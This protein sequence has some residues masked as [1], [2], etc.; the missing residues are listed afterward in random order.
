MADFVEILV[1]AKKFIDGH[2]TLDIIATVDRINEIDDS[3]DGTLPA[4]PDYITDTSSEATRVPENDDDSD[5]S[6]SKNSKTV[7]NHSNFVG[8]SI[9]SEYSN[10]VDNIQQKIIINILIIQCGQYNKH[11][12]K[13]QRTFGKPTPINRSVNEIIYSDSALAKFEKEQ[14]TETWVGEMRQM[15]IHALDLQQL[16][17]GTKILPTG[18]KCEKC[19]LTRNLWLNLTDG[20]ILCGRKFFDGT[21]GNKHAAQHFSVSNYALAVKLG[22]I[23]ADGRADVFSYAE[24]DMVI[25]PY[26]QKHFLHFGINIGLTLRRLKSPWLRWSWR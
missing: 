13:I 10:G 18:W 6:S 1:R 11:F 14:L 17:N 23:S 2:W 12:L 21:G 9:Q 25:D 5:D 24:D 4:F 3:Y 8:R 22:T 15:S 26:L 7:A 19:D 16:E 20:S